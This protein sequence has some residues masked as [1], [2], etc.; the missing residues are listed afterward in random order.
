[1]VNLLFFD[2][3]SCFLPQRSTSIKSLS[4]RR[5]NPAPADGEKDQG[6]KMAFR[7]VSTFHRKY[8]SLYS[9]PK[10]TIFW[11]YF[12]ISTFHI[13]KAEYLGYVTVTMKLL[14]IQKRLMCARSRLMR[15]PSPRVLRSTPEHPRKEAAGR[16]RRRSHP[17]AGKSVKKSA[18]GGN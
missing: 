10:N 18:R 16:N 12:T 17:A 8:Y 9:P 7:L 5:H 1:M 3:F 15:T 14:T 6:H 4:Q 11:G 13:Q 2:C